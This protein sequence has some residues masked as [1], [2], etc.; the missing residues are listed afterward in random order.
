MHGHRDSVCCPHPVPMFPNL[1]DP[2]SASNLN[3]SENILLS[4]KFSYKNYN[5]KNLPLVESDQ[6]T[7]QVYCAI[8]VE[9]LSDTLEKSSTG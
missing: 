7:K 9:E 4:L 1:F 3:R 8:L 5:K 6:M 2:L